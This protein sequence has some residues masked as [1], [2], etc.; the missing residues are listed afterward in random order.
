MHK[1]QKRKAK[2]FKFFKVARLPYL[3]FIL[4]IEPGNICNLNCPLCPTG[5]QSGGAKKG[6]MKFEFFKNI[7]DQL[8]NSLV[9]VNL[10]NWGEPLLN[11]DLFKIIKYI[12]DY[13]KNIFVVT[14]TNLNINEKGVLLK[15]LNSGIDEVIVSCDGAS[16]EAYNKYRV[17]GDF[18]LVME[19]LKFLADQK[20]KL[21]SNVDIVWNFLVFKHNEHEIA[22]ARGMAEKL[23][24]SFRLGLMRTSMK[25]EV[26]KPHQEAIKKDLDWIPDNPE[27]SAYDKVGLTAKKIIKTCKKPWQEIAINWNGEVFPCCAVYGDSFNFGDTA[28][29]SISKIWNNEKYILARKEIINKKENPFTICGICKNNGFMHM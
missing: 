8:K 19:N 15:L 12:K 1:A 27:Y 24:V 23:G 13:K 4:G 22:T 10:Y 28:K 6:F 14:S 11:K 9:T 3:P 18:N 5:A 2:I 20:R 17:G 7:F 21:G 26:L 16:V 29:D 25:D